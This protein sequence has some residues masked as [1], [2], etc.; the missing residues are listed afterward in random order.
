MPIID[1]GYVIENGLL[2]LEGT[3]EELMDNPEVRSAYM[4]V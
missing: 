2:V 1:R 4:G 3:R